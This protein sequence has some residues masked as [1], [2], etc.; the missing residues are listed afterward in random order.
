MRIIEHLLA[1]NS[2]L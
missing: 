2:E 1:V